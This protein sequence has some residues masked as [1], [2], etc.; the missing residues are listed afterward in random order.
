[1]REETDRAGIAFAHMEKIGRPCPPVPH[2]EFPLFFR[3]NR[4][5]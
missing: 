5:Q 4:R 1:M 3:E 2:W